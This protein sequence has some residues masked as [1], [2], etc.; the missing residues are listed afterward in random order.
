V[1]YVHLYILELHARGRCLRRHYDGER[2]DSRNE[3]SDRGKEAEDILDTHEGRVHGG[4]LVSRHESV[5]VYRASRAAVVAEVRSILT[6]FRK[7]SSAL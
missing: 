7:A 4:S 2:N 6:R 1:E 3:E 5:G